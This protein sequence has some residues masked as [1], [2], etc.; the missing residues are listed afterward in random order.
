MVLSKLDQLVRSD[1]SQD[2]VR[3]HG[4]SGLVR[5]PRILIVEDD[6]E[7]R[8]ILAAMVADCGCEVSLASDGTLAIA[9]AER[10][11]PD[12][13]LLDLMLP[14]RSGITVLDQLKARRIRRVPVV[15]MSGSREPRHRTL[16]VEHGADAFLAKP[17]DE[18]HFLQLIEQ[19]LPQFQRPLVSMH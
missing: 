14:R 1:F 6:P 19:L 12:L 8:E 9:K 16:A 10:D 11:A 5:P 13:V 3:G 2:V 15:M 4:P 17:F 7:V 18:S